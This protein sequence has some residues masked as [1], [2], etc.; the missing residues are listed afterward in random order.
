MSD[1]A[2]IDAGAALDA[3]ADPGEF[4][5]VALERGKTWLTEALAH[6]DLA[7]LCEL[8]GWAATLRTATMQKQLGRDAELAA[9]ELVRRAERC[10]GIGI[11]MGQ[12]AGEITVPHIS[13]GD[14]VA[15]SKIVDYVTQTTWS[16]NPTSGQA[17][18]RDLVDNVTDEQFEQAVEE[19]KDEGNLSRANVVRHVKN[20]P[21]SDKVKVARELAAKGHTT[22]Q[23]AVHLGYS[24]KGM[25]EFCKR[26]GIEV[27]ADAVVRGTR[28]LDSR[29][30]V[31]GTVDTVQGLDG[32]G[33]LDHVDYAALDPEDVKGWLPVLNDAIRSLT[34]LRNRLKEVASRG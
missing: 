15:D 1:L 4:V 13:A 33:L 17:G 34:T 29:R 22:E 7:A 28:K 26:H 8:K 3:A 19:A 18:I 14:D 30:I 31:A 27:H 16:G 32:G 9:T 21:T 2:I 20:K 6:G 12:Q 10:I 11:R 5:V 24:R 23:I 25:V